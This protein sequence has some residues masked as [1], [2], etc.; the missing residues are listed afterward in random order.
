MRHNFSQQTLQHHTFCPCAKLHYKV[1]YIFTSA[2]QN[3][4]IT[5]LPRKGKKEEWKDGKGTWRRDRYGEINRKKGR[6][7][8]EM[9]GDKRECVGKTDTGE[10]NSRKLEEKKE[11]WQWERED[12]EETDRGK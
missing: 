2:L 11:G 6:E 8:E 7:Q 3:L 5:I 9:E 12:G 1:P 10:M 4:L